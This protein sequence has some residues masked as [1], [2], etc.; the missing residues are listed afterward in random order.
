MA[1]AAEAK[2]AFKS[3]G[4]ALKSEKLP[5]NRIFSQKSATKVNS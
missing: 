5:K 1:G 3:V 2:Q 4:K